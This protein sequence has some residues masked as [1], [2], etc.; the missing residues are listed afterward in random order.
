MLSVVMPNVANNHFLLNIVMLSII[1]PN[2]ANN[3][4]I[5]SVFMLSVVMINVIMASVV[6]P[7]LQARLMTLN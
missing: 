2:V 7:T 3:P 1:M 5:L 6:A 4:S